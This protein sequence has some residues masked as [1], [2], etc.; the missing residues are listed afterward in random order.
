MVRASRDEDVADALL[1]AGDGGGVSS[2]VS[3]EDQA[4][5]GEGDSGE[6]GEGESEE[7]GEEEEGDSAEEAGEGGHG[8]G[9]EGGHGQAHAGDPPLLYVAIKPINPCTLNPKP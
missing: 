9:G 6:E 1:D 7:E 4:E 8:V 3:D 2:D 5:E